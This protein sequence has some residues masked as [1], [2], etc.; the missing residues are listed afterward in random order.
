[1]MEKVF[2]FAESHQNVDRFVSRLGWG[3]VSL[4]AVALVVL[5]VAFAIK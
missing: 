4:G 3:A 2:H 1:M 5:A